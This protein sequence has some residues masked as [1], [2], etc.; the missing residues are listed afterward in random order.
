MSESSSS[1]QRRK[2]GILGC[3]FFFEESIIVQ[4]RAAATHAR[5][6]QNTDSASIA[7]KRGVECVPHCVVPSQTERA[8]RERGGAK[9]RHGRK[10]AAGGT[11]VLSDG[12]GIETGAWDR[13]R[14]TSVERSEVK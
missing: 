12:D 8:M 13:E 11:L 4:T 3:F 14:E 1:Q 7:V 6:V 5:D 10:W 9:C 2:T